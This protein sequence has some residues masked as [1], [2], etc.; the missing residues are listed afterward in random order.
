MLFITTVVCCLTLMVI[1]SILA[2]AYAMDQM[3]ERM[4]HIETFLVELINHND[5]AV[6]PEKD[7]MQ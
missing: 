3:R 6:G 2:Q 5:L 7:E 4:D 1:V